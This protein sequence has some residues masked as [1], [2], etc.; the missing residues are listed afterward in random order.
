MKKR[1]KKLFYS[2]LIVIMSIGCFNA[3][4]RV[5]REVAEATLPYLMEAVGIP[6]DARPNP[7]P[8]V[9]YY[10]QVK[11]DA[12]ISMIYTDAGQREMVDWTQNGV[13]PPTLTASG[14]VAANTYTLTAG[15]LDA[16]QKL[17]PCGPGTFSSYA[18]HSSRLG[19]NLLNNAGHLTNICKC[20]ILGNNATLDVAITNRMGRRHII[21]IINLFPSAGRSIDTQLAIML[22]ILDVCDT[23]DQIKNIFNQILPVDILRSGNI[24][25]AVLAA[26]HVNEYSY[27]PI[28]AISV[29]NAGRREGDCVQTLY[30]H[31]INI[32]VQNDV[33]NSCRFNVGHLPQT[34]QTYYT[35]QYGQIINHVIS[36][37]VTYTEAGK[38]EL[39]K[40]DRWK[41]NLGGVNNAGINIGNISDGYLADI[42]RVLQF[43]QGTIQVA[44]ALP[45]RNVNAPHNIA[46]S[47]GIVANATDASM[48]NALN[49]LDGRGN[50][51]DG[52]R[53]LIGSINNIRVP[54]PANDGTLQ[55][56]ACQQVVYN[57]YINAINIKNLDWV[58][59]II[60]IVD[61]LWNR[62]IIIAVNNAQQ[63]QSNPNGGHAEIITIQ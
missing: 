55:V 43:L 14:F 39:N 49:A 3:E 8:N 63:T 12:I 18:T 13:F 51:L 5:T 1:I 26:L 47:A 52:P 34:L 58:T 62:K 11:R 23:A 24:D 33:T 36:I 32:A 41:S 29:I 16:L 61:R 40:H 17:F 2:S 9:P 4:A 20:L 50:F 45:Q 19:Y 44:L 15:T 56:N 46:L 54:N 25:A 22:F 57:A 48:Q 10:S 35:S 60:E 59:D 21:D 7:T 42:V 27:R 31:L 6:Q 28:S 37:P 38:T 30:R 53:F